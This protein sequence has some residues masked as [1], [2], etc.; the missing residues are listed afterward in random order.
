L[1]IIEKQNEKIHIF[2]EQAN[3]IKRINRYELALNV[4]VHTYLYSTFVGYPCIY[5]QFK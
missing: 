3:I 4:I 5:L 1:G 2:L